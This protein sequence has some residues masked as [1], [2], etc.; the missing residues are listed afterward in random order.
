[1]NI[2][3]IFF[4][5]D[6]FWKAFEKAWKAKLIESGERKRNRNGNLC[7]SEIM[8][9]MILFHQSCYRNF[10]T[11]YIKHVCIFYNKEFPNLV[12]YPRFVTLMKKVLIPMSYYLNSNKGIKTGISYVDS[13]SIKVCHNKRIHRHKVFDGIAKRG[14]STMGWFFGFKLH[15]IVNEFGQIISFYLSDGA[16]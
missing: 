2:N 5:V 1:M 11:F 6:N 4:K 3:S 13:T 7:E 8:T 12:S 9:I 10:K 16:L 14:K 15:I